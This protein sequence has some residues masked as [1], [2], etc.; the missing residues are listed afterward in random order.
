MVTVVA[1]MVGGGGA[2]GATGLAL[3]VVAVVASAAAAA[4]GVAL[5]LPGE[6]LVIFGFVRILTQPNVVAGRSPISPYLIPPRL[7]SS[8]LI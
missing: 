7:I 3:A 6:L 1:V 5:L 4:L 2:V 8:H